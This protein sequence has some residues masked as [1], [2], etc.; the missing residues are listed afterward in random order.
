MLQTLLLLIWFQKTAQTPCHI[1]CLCIKMNF[2]KVLLRCF[3]DFF[4]NVRHTVYHWYINHN[5]TFNAIATCYQRWLYY[6]VVKQLWLGLLC[7]QQHMHVL[8]NTVVKQMENELWEGGSLGPILKRTLGY[9]Q[10]SNTS[11]NPLITLLCTFSTYRH[12]L[13]HF[14]LGKLEKDLSWRTWKCPRYGL[15]SQP[16]DLGTSALLLSAITHL[17]RT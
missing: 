9:Y 7:C 2:F 16:L 8:Y 15:N 4:T 14:Q 5:H 17:E 10:L 3:E 13:S 12:L 6:T 1:K 11:I